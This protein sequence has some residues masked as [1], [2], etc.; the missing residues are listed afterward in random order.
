MK[1]SAVL[2]LVLAG[3]LLGAAAGYL[4]PRSLSAD[5]PGAA[6]PASDVILDAD[7]M[8]DG[9][10]ILPVGADGTAV[11]PLSVGGVIYVPAESVER[12]GYVLGY[13]EASR[14]IYYTR[15]VEYSTGPLD[16]PVYYA[17]D[18]IPVT[19]LPDQQQTP[20]A[21]IYLAAGIYV[22]G[23]D[24]PAGKYDVTARSGSGN[25]MGTVASLPLHSL[26]EILSANPGTYETM[27]YSGLRLADGDSFEVRGD[28][29]IRMDPVD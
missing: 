9:I 4:I 21:S 2:F 6:L 20:Q 8:C 16:V 5:D 23:E 11:R 3:V 24:V 27:S 26:N 18:E 1:K 22:V 17:P 29:Q 10:S 13:N 12:L 19:E 25:F 7:V 15:N 28:L 14:I